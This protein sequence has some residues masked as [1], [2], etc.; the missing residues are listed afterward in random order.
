MSEDGHKYF[1]GQMPEMPYKRREKEMDKNF[2]R[3][4][5]RALILIM[6]LILR[7]RKY[8][9]DEEEQ[10]IES[11]VEEMLDHVRQLG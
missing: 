5:L 6:S 9:S 4:V 11:I 1:F 8:I 7:E 10:K 3:I 2:Q